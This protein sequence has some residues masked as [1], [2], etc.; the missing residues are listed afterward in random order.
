MYLDRLFFSQLTEISDLY[1]DFIMYPIEDGDG[2]GSSY[3]WNLLTAPQTY[4]DRAPRPYD[5]GRGVGGGS[6]ING[7]CWTRGGS[8]DFDA[9]VALGNLGWG[10]DDLLPYFKKARR[11][12]DLKIKY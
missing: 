10:W 2:L 9:W 8:A 12:G 5:L 1:E 3:D 7:L 4:L 6:L 11:L